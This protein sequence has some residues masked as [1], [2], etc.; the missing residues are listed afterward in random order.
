MRILIINLTRFGDLLQTQPV[1]HA[2]R[3]AGHETGLVCLDNFA[4]AGR[5]LDGVDALVALPGSGLL[6]ALD[7]DWRRCAG[8]LEQWVDLVR[9]HFA[10][11]VILNLTSTPAARLLGRLLL[12]RAAEA[13]TPAPVLRGFSVDEHGFGSNGTL[14]GAFFEASTRRR[15]CS[16]YNLADVFRKAA[17]VGEVP[18]RYALRRPAPEAVDAMRF[19]LAEAA[20]TASTASTASSAGTGGGRGAASFAAFQ[21]GAS[22]ERRR[23]PVRHFAELGRRMY[24]TFGCMPVLLGSAAER[25]LAESYL[26]AGAPAVDLI[27]A[28]S[29]G[30]VSAAL[31]LCRLL[32]TNDTGTMHLAAGLGVPSLALFLATAQAWDTGPY[33]EDCCCLEP[34]LPCHPCG[35]G[36]VCP[37]N[38]AC[39]EKISAEAVWLLAETRLRHGRWP[40]A[41]DPKTASE[42]RVWLTVR[43]AYGF[44]DLHSLS[45]HGTEERSVWLRLQRHFYRQ[46]LDVGDAVGTPAS[47]SSRRTGQHFLPPDQEDLAGVRLLA[48][49][50]RAEL[51]SALRQAEEL[52]HLLLRQGEVLTARP[53]AQAGQRFLATAQ[54]IAAFLESCDA[55]NAF[56]ALGRLWTAVSQERGGELDTVTELAALFQEFLC[57]W[58]QLLEDY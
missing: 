28:T 6:A 47:Q 50:R 22:E 16:P 51:A 23:W 1:V 54:R 10:P 17:G 40:D 21:L 9:R 8:F 11:D 33:L 15:G 13:G 49:G 36:T 26:R 41:A 56:D 29:L 4:E 19:R 42:A 52:L 32:V 34:A 18:A 24:E 7:G 53:T 57:M 46:F 58:R 44:L 35:F 31:T 48:A 3:D 38:V 45:G 27:G 5:L 37:E 30:E 14:W 25:E 39:R 55:G 12:L 20:S 43:D 2:L